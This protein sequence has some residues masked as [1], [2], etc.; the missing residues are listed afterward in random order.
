MYFVQAQH[1]LP[2]FWTYTT[3]ISN[4]QNKWTTKAFS[5]TPS[6]PDTCFPIHIFTHINGKNY[7]DPFTI[8]FIT[9][10]CKC[11]F[12]LHKIH[13]YLDN[14]KNIC[15]VLSPSFFPGSRE[16][17]SCN[18]PEQRGSQFLC[19]EGQ[20]QQH[21][22][23]HQTIIIALPHGTCFLSMFQCS[24]VGCSSHLRSWHR[25]S[26]C[27]QLHDALSWRRNWRVTWHSFI[28]TAFPVTSSSHK[29]QPHTSY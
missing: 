1:I 17:P 27:W 19:M 8:L 2:L 25:S 10:F 3:L 21:L 7:S 11:E 14:D 26:T 24:R 13:S 22:Y 15:L 20:L 18:P 9:S 16:M 23:K 5:N 6:R 4:F 12:W 28:N 29:Q